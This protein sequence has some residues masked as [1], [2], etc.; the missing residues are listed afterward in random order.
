MAAFLIAVH[1]LAATIWVGG[2]F[3]AYLA[4]RPAAANLS[5]AERLPL[6]SRALGRFFLWVWLAV[7]SLIVTGYALVFG[8]FGGMGAVGTHIHVMHGLG[9]LMFLA[10]GHLFFVPWKRLR[11]ALAAGSVD[12]GARHL[13]QIRWIVAFNVTLGLIVVAVAAGGRYGFA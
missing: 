1:V 6:W 2:M 5:L 13:N 9:W 3:F 10:F 4:L 7:I 8:F 11:A 12:E